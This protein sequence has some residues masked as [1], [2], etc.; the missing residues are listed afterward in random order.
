MSSLLRVELLAVAGEFLVGKYTPL[1]S[2]SMTRPITWAR[3]PCRRRTE[4]VSL[5]EPLALYRGS[6]SECV[7]RAS[8]KRGYG[9]QSEFVV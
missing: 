7:S 1:L 4:S 3:R 6:A 2:P 8:C 9:K 5:V